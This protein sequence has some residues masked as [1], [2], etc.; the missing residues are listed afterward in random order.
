MGNAIEPAL[1]I[2]SAH[3]LSGS[4][5]TVEDCHLSHTCTR[6]RGSGAMLVGVLTFMRLGITHSAWTLEL[7]TRRHQS[8]QRPL[9][10]MVPSMM[11]MAGIPLLILLAQAWMVHG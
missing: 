5:Q 6:I 3:L 2:T 9:I 4:N 11:A 10:T 1:K 8:Q 7:L